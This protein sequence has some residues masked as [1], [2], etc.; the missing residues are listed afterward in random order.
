MHS[1][2]QAAVKTISPLTGWQGT[3]CSRRRRDCATECVPILRQAAATLDFSQP[4]AVMLLGVL[5]LVGDAEDPWGIV[6]TLMDAVPPGNYLVISHPALDIS[7]AQAKGQRVY[8][9]NVATPQTLRTRDEVARLSRRMAASRG[10]PTKPFSVPS[11]PSRRPRPAER[12]VNETL[13][14]PWLSPAIMSFPVRW[15]GAL[16]APLNVGDVGFVG[17]RHHQGRESSLEAGE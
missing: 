1:T 9:Q 4:V 13:K 17:A 12:R 2:D 16:A 5:H 11:Q 8:N 15:Q 7:K 10:R 6:A 3:G 14:P